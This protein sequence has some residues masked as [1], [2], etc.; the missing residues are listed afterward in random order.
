MIIE[1]KRTHLFFLLIA[2]GLSTIIYSEDPWSF[3]VLADWHGAETFATK[4]GDTSK[5]WKNSL[6][7]IKYIKEKYGGD[8][9]ML[10][11]DSNAG[12]WDR[13]EFIDKLDPTLTPQEAV[14]HAGEN[15][16]STM[17]ELFQQ[18]GYDEML[19]CLGDHEIGGN[20]W[21]FGSSKFDSLDEYR[22]TFTNG[23]NRNNNGSFHFNTPIGN[24]M[25]RPLG[26]PFATTSYAYQHKNVLF[27]TV[28]AFQ[29]S[30]DDTGFLDRVNGRGGE[31]VVSCTVAGDHLS[32]FESVLSEASK[33][34]SIRRIVVQAHVP[35]IQPVRKIN[36][37]GQF[38]DD[39]ENSAFWITMRKYNVDI[40]FAGEVHAVTVRKDNESN[41]HQIVSRGNT[42]SNFLKVYVTDNSIQIT[43]YNEIGQKPRYNNNYESNGELTLFKWGTEVSFSESS[44]ILKIVEVESSIVHLNFDEIVSLESRQVVGMIHNDSKDELV[45]KEIDMRG[46]DCLHS[47]PNEGSFGQLYDAQVA[48]LEF[49]PG[50]VG[51]FAGSFSDSS[52]LALYATGPHSGGNIISYAFWMKTMKFKEMILVHYG[53][54]FGT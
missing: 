39:A 51:E 14:L 27:I 33:D 23:F 35:I 41:L 36:C 53:S 30:S 9:I 12:K 11:G 38:F 18:G 31:G 19:M 45:G 54:V 20:S 21:Q 13:Q 3:I 8:L 1:V 37:S 34:S 15:C 48:N 44:G 42:F 17:K 6:G 49:V 50:K 47:M 24:V 2:A 32:W 5:A 25:S 40:Y 7:T 29:T 52:R 16:Y 26:T 4:P 28:D 22:E 43:A 46:I 10:P